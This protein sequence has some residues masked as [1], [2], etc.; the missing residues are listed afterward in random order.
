MNRRLAVK[1]LP[2]GALAAV[3][4]GGIGTLRNYTIHEL[5]TLF[6]VDADPAIAEALEAS[7]RRAALIVELV[8]GVARLA[9]PP[10]VSSGGAIDV[11]LPRPAATHQLGAAAP[12]GGF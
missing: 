5:A 3:R 7:D 12:A 11:R 10:V 8:D 4:I 1:R 2:D 6:E 9:P